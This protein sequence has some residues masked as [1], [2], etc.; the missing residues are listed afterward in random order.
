[1]SDHRSMEIDDSDAEK[2]PNRQRRNSNSSSEE[3]S[4][5]GYQ[6]VQY[7]KAVNYQNHSSSQQNRPSQQHQQSQQGRPTSSSSGQQNPRQK[8]QQSTEEVPKKSLKNINEALK[9]ALEE[10]AQPGEG[11][12]E[13]EVLPAPATEFDPSKIVPSEREREKDD[14]DDEKANTQQPQLIKR[15]MN[16]EGKKPLTKM[17]VFSDGRIKEE[18]EIISGGEEENDDNEEDAVD[19]PAHPHPSS[20]PTVHISPL[21]QSNMSERAKYIPVR[22]SYEERKS[23]R[24]VCAAMNVSDYT[25]A[26][27]IAFKNP[28]KRYHTQLQYIVAFLTA[29]IAGNNYEDGQ[30]IFENRHYALFEEMIMSML[31]IVRRYKITNPEKLRS[32]YGKLIY[33]MQDAISSNIKPLLDCTVNQPVRTVY[34]LLSQYNGLAM[35]DD[36]LIHIATNEILSEKNKSRQMI[37]QEIKKKERAIEQ[38]VKRFSPILVLGYR[39]QGGG[40]EQTQTHTGR[41][42]TGLTPNMSREDIIRNCLYSISDNNSFLNS[43]MKP[44]TDCIELLKQYFSP[45]AVEEGYN[46]GIHEGQE[47]SRLS[48]SHTMQYHYVLQ[49]LTLWSVIVEDMFRLWYLAEKDLLNEKIPYDLKNTGQGLQRVQPSPYVYKAMHE[50]LIHVQQTLNVSNTHLGSSWIGTSVIHL[51]DHNVPN[52]LVFIDKYTQISR[53]LGPL[54]S[55]LKNLEILNE[56]N[57]SISRYLESYCQDQI[58]SQHYSNGNNGTAGA[59][60]GAGNGLSACGNH[61]GYFTNTSGHGGSCGGQLNPIEKIKKDILYDFFTHGFDGSGGDN[62]FDAGSCIDGR[63]TSAWNWCSQLANKPYYPLF[64]LTGFT[65]FDGQFDK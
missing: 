23:L 15:R 48:H 4:N 9:K 55:T 27:D 8:N 36:P 11:D 14:E 6:P 10:A 22:L 16:E 51:G 42:G 37:Q 20:I 62:F 50:I 40:R 7:K 33:L 38:L 2:N 41:M 56:E 1:M 5:D 49:S 54:I 21:P 31:E 19:A 63:L 44:I 26:V 13:P 60:A 24:L 45:N 52:A 35:L 39:G 17:E 25:N 43:N 59:G 65:S 28:A 47:G 46:L 30:H 3:S 29:I 61:G 34:D 58:N 12:E 57:S 53:I 64:K 32:E 18:G